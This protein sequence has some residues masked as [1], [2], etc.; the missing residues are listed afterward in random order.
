MHSQRIAHAYAPPHPSSPHRAR[1]RDHP[2]V[3]ISCSHMASELSGS[4]RLQGTRTDFIFKTVFFTIFS[5]N[6]V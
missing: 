3:S 1:G 6:V 4:W 2:E 5:G